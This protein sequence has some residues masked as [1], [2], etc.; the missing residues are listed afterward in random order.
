[1]DEI[2]LSV[3]EMRKADKYTIDNFVTSK[4]LM[5]RA[6]RAVFEALEWQK[7]VAII[8]GVG[9][10]AGDAY[11]LAN[12]LKEKGI[13]CRLFLIE[14]RFSQDAKYYFD[15]CMENGIEYEILNSNTDFEDYAYI[16]DAIYGTGFKGKLKKEL[17]QLICKI[18]SSNAFVVSIDINSGMN[19]DIGECE[20]CVKSSLT[21]SIGY[22]KKGLLSEFAK[23]KIGRLINVDIGI[24][25]P[26]NK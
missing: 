24:V 11:V 12:L 10:N 20:L 21:I 4:E 9:N 6:G 17:A 3:E 19:G 18:N 16:V 22:L 2:V 1:M 8:C 23:D 13:Y 7:N 25:I 14:E 5:Y 15:K 26:E